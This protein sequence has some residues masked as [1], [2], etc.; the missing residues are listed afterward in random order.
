MSTT[1]V[2]DPTNERDIARIVGVL[3][4]IK[5]CVRVEACAYRPRRSDRQ[6]AWYWGCIMPIAARALTDSQGETFDSETAHEF[7]KSLFLARPVVNRETGELITNIVGSSAVLDTV[8]F[9]D[10]VEQVRQ[11]L[12][13][14]LGVEVPDPAAFDVPSR[15]RTVE[16]A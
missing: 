14:Y 7:F 10:Y 8:R 11:W 3:R 6:N 13:E 1:L 4:G 2:I 15:A 5:G 12:A 16:A 9:T